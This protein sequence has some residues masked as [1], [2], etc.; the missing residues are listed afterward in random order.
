MKRRA[1]FGQWKTPPQVMYPSGGQPGIKKSVSMPMIASDGHGAYPQ[2][3]NTHR[4][5][6]QDGWRQDSQQQQQHQPGMHRGEGSRVDNMNGGGAGGNIRRTTSYNNVGR[7]PDTVPED[8]SNAPGSRTPGGDADMSTMLGSVPPLH[9]SGLGGRTHSDGINTSSKSLS[10]LMPGS[11][12]GGTTGKRTASAGG[13]SHGGLVTGGGKGSARMQSLKSGSSGSLSTDG[14]KTTASAPAAV[15]ELSGA[16]AAAAAEDDEE[17]RSKRLARNR[18]SARMRRLRKKTIVETLEIECEQLTQTTTKIKQWLQDG[19][20]LLA[21]PDL[22][23]SLLGGQSDPGTTPADAAAKALREQLVAVLGGQKEA[24]TISMARR[25]AGMQLL[26]DR[27]VALARA[28]EEDSLFNSGLSA[29]TLDPAS[30]MSTVVRGQERAAAHARAQ[31]GYRRA[32]TFQLASHLPVTE[33]EFAERNKRPNTGATTSGGVMGMMTDNS[34]S[35]S[36]PLRGSDAAMTGSGGGGRV[37][38]ASRLLGLAVPMAAASGSGS[39]NANMMNNGAAEIAAMRRELRDMLKLSDDQQRAVS[40][41]SSISMDKEAVKAQA[42]ARVCVA[43]ASHDWF[44][45]PCLEQTVSQFRG[46]LTATQM[47]KFLVWSQRNGEAIKALPIAV[48]DTRHTHQQ[49][50][51]HHQQHQQQQQKQQ[52]QQQHLPQ[53]SAAV[54]HRFPSS[55]PL[56]GPPGHS[57]SG[58]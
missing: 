1:V 55:S 11:G 53:K 46:V 40:Q 54:P 42:L 28:L 27:Q 58:H 50:H 26:V 56:Q 38:H 7:W 37:S 29:L 14:A 33:Q 16:S 8:Y 15:G 32:M 19:D 52:H 21:D 17:K 30:A 4:Q 25:R 35:V 34:S 48:T 43:V 23:Q 3:G 45:F 10:T 49:Q 31:D 18:A 2:H 36:L 5:E 51:H 41:I 39:I 44:E 24:H 9:S 47:N 20:L 12:G 13:L 22:V 6:I 57:V